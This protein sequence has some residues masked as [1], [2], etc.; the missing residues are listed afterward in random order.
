[1][2]V[3]AI[4]NPVAGATKQHSALRVMLKRL[5]RMGI[6]T[7]VRTTTCLGDGTRLARQAAEIADYVV[8]G[9]GDGTVREV[10][11]GLAGS[12]VPLMIWPTG[13]ENLVAKSIGFRAHPNLIP[14]CITAGRTLALDVGTANEHCFLVVAGVGFD[15]EVVERLAGCRRGHITHLSYFG[16]IWRTFWSH[17]FPELR[18]F[19]QDRLWWQGRG[20]AFV[21]NLSRYSLG[22]PVV[23][24]ALPDDGLLDL[25]VLPCRN[26]MTL[27]AHSLR[28][29]LA[30]HVERGGAR[31]LR[32]TE[33]RIESSD[34]APLELDG[35]CAGA[36][37]VEFAVRPKALRVR[38][39]L[40]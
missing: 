40:S 23:R 4:V 29:V 31:Y 2:N 39:P 21:G 13:T 12:T 14:A 28:T 35:D 37:P 15:A 22:L 3:V 36:L 11:Q 17:R 32:F 7:Q 33:L 24:D 5:G 26:Q 6:Q 8:A 34:Y 25:L 10:V 38:L 27:L 18:V 16:P 19:H 30:R 20:L 9:G 1:M